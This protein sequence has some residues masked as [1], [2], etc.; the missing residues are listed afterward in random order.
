MAKTT[1]DH[2]DVTRIVGPAY[3]GPLTLTSP[4]IS[5][6]TYT[7]TDST[8]SAAGARLRA[9]VAAGGTIITETAAGGTGTQG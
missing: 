7:V 1:T 6:H 2:V 3:T 9:L 8:T 5:V 4:G